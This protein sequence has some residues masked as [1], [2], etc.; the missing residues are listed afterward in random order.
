MKI[1]FI[2]TWF[3]YP[4][5]NGSR[6][7]VYHLLKG[8]SQKHSVDLVS[9]LPPERRIENPHS[10]FSWLNQV[11]V[12]RRDPFWRDP[13]QGFTAHFSTVPRD[14]LRSYSPEMDRLVKDTCAQTEYQVVIASVLNA[15]PY[16]LRAV[17]TPKLLEE[18]N[19]TTR[20]MEERYQ[21]QKK[22]L[23]R[24]YGWV[25]WRKCLGYERKLYPQFQ[26]VSM[27]SEQ[28]RLAVHKAI[29]WYPGQLD[30][31]PNGV[32]LGTRSPGTSEPKPD[33]LIFNGSVTY[34]ANHEAMRF[35]TSQ[36]LPIIWIKRPEVHLTITGRTDDAD[37]TWVPK[38]DRIRVTGFLEDVRQPVADSWLAIAPLLDGGGSRLKILEAMALGVPVVA[39]SKGA[40][41]LDV[42][43]GEHILIADSP[44]SFAHACLNLLENREQRQQLACNARLLVEANYDW[45]QISHRFCSLVEEIAH[46]S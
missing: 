41:G 2:S 46:E 26:G 19:F 14:I 28:D 33:T 34:S 10:L 44:E 36:V 6:I 3:P 23:R 5:D 30:V 18:H 22:I 24:F 9:F 37:I 35:F 31:I 32:D 40:E 8:L 27:V 12:I 15:A 7:R 16:A 25:T 43:P 39:T 38:D 45:Q 1:L 29:P 17:Q 11:A 13:R 42:I 21:S 4:L 20:W